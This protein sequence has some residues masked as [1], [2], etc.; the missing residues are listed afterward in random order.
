MALKEDF[1]PKRL[2][3]YLIILAIA[4]IFVVQWGPGAKGCE[5]PLGAPTAASTGGAAR[6][7]DR[8][9]SQREFN[10][11]YT[12]ELRRYA[13]SY[14]RFGQELTEAKAREMG[15]PKR[16]LDQMVDAEL[17]AQEAERQGIAASDDEVIKVLQQH[18]EFK[19]ES[20]H[21]EQAK[22]YDAVRNY[23][24]KTPQEFENDIRRELAIQKLYRVVGESAQV[25]DDEVKN[26]YFRE[27]DKAK[28][29]YVRFTP[30][31][32]AG[33]AGEPKPADVESFKK[34]H[35]KEISDDYTANSYVY[36]QPER[37]HA[38]HILV[39]VAKDAPQ[40]KKDEAR[41][42]IEDYK[43]QI[44]GG[45]DFAALAKEV[46][47]DQGSKASGGDLGFKPR[48]E[49]VPEFSNA[50]FSLKPGEVSAPV[51]SPFGIHLIKVEEKK[52]AESKSLE[53]VS[54]EIA[55]KLWT[56]EKS[57]VLAKA[58]AEKALAA[59]KGGK[60][61]EEQYPATKGKLQ[62]EAAATP[63]AKTTEDFSVNGESIPQLPP[64][65]DLMKDVAAQK[66]EALLDKVYAEGDTFLV[67]R[68]DG[69][70]IPSEDAFTR[71]LSKLRDAAIQT[72]E[73]ETQEAFVKALRKGA[74]I[75]L[76]K[77]ALGER[78]PGGMPAGDD[79]G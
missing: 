22:Y 18:P 77:D 60:K 7:N 43:K 28:L 70:T 15:L 5:S 68:V 39:A 56:R 73:R 66:G 74:T 61:L 26:Q 47:D 44:D 32:Y 25:A 75:T 9:I 41:A 20:G 62:F 35:Q 57:R 23:Y 11:A 21:F 6:V 31:M 78:A 53:S 45:K 8:D 69:R 50:A 58:E 2:G 34:D 13:E 36:Q 72:K 24:R 38:R 52:P 67:A 42:K 40:A 14:R 71:D 49:W 48:E 30:G 46:S 64:T 16:V 27:G 54:G 33:K 3:Y 29:T 63:E 1:E 10:Q 55:K 37:V 12:N 4:F 65:P 51:E 59:A 79:E 17:I 76:N 19:G